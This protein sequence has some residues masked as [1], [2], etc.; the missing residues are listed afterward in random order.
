MSSIVFERPQTVLLLDYLDYDKAAAKQLLI[1]K[2]GWVDYGGKHYESVY[3][4]FYQG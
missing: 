1:E 2:F 4:R 3:T